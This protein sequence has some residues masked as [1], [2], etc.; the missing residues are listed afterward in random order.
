VHLSS[1]ENHQ[2]SPNGT[3]LCHLRAFTFVH[4]SLS[5]PGSMPF[6][7]CELSG[8]SSRMSARISIYFLSVYLDRN[9]SLYFLLS[10]MRLAISA[11]GWV[12]FDDCELV[13]NA[14]RSPARL[15]SF[16]RTC[17]GVSIHRRLLLSPSLS[18]SFS[19]IVFDVCKLLKRSAKA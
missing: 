15:P 10:I 17:S 5:E 4:V 18:M 8:N 13:G 6:D 12:P 14:S 2:A 1:S 9:L 19:R 11:P 16:F 7:D 3:A